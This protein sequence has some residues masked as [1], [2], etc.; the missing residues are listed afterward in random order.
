MSDYETLGPH[1]TPDELGAYLDRTLRSE[2]ASRVEDHLAGCAECRGEAV[3]IGR[4][5]QPVED[6]AGRRKR[7]YWIAP[8]AAAAI[9]GIWLLGPRAG[10]VSDRGEPALRTGDIEGTVAITVLTPIASSQLQPDSVVFAWRRAEEDV[11]Y[12]VTLLDEGGAVLWRG[13]TEDTTIALPVDV[14]LGQG[15]RFFWYVDALLDEARSVT[16]GVQ[17]FFTLP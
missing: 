3:A 1:L 16:S 13:A 7:A 17:E 9:A 10:D 4:L 15:A 14:S 2:A 12:Q 11:V 8:V 5:I 6:G